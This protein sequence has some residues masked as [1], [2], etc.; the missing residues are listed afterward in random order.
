MENGCDRKN[1]TS[2]LLGKSNL[3]FVVHLK[4]VFPGSKNNTFCSYGRHEKLPPSCYEKEIKQNGKF[5][6]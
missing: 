6:N 3:V 2:P 1:W 4:Q 5:H